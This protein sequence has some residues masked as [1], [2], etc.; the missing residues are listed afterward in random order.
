MPTGIVASFN[1]VSGYGFI[2]PT[3]GGRDY[4]VHRDE[5]EK[6]RLATLKPEDRVEFEVLVARNGKLSA[7]NLRLLQ[8]R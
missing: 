6:A 1:A 7:I 2:T 3:Y 8:T 4:F 5:V